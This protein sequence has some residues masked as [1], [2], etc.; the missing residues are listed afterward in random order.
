MNQLCKKHLSCPLDAGCCSGCLVWMLNNAAPCVCDWQAAW[1]C[2]DRLSCLDLCDF[3]RT[4]VASA[5]C[6][7]VSSECDAAELCEAERVNVCYLEDNSN[8]EHRLV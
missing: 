5:W 4:S 8:D 6:C 3:G 7:L 2:R 1:L